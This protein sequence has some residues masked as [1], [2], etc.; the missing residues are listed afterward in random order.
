ML[1]VHPEGFEPP[2]K[3]FEA[4]Y[5]IQLSYGCVITR[6]TFFLLLL[7]CYLL[8]SYYSQF[9]AVI[10]VLNIEACSLHRPTLLRRRGASFCSVMFGQTSASSALISRNTSCPSGISSSA[11]IAPTGHSGLTEG[12]VNAL[13]WVDYQEVGAFIETVYRT[14]F[15]TVCVFALDAV[16]ADDKGHGLAL[17]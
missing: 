8:T 15:Y 12:A 6:T 11:K 9:T 17:I 2:T 14:N 4:T 5:S 10:S 3:W 13:V 7:T 1:L 16:V